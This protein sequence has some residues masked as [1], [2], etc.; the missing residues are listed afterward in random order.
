MDPSKRAIGA[1]GPLLTPHSTITFRVG[2]CHGL[3]L[4]YADYLPKELPV[5]HA[6]LDVVIQDEI[7][8]LKLRV[9]RNGVWDSST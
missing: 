6:D 3:L 7:N 4:R 5:S 8:I 1:S 9:L 2:S